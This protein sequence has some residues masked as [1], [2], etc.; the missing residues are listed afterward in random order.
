[1]VDVEG[2]GDLDAYLWYS[3]RLYVNDGAAIF[4]QNLATLPQSPTFADL[5][6]DGAID[7]LSQHIIRLSL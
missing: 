2:D 5:N 7:I 1:M 4:S 3:G 6:G